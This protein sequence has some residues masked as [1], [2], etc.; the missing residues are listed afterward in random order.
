MEFNLRNY[1]WRRYQS[2]IEHFCVNID[3]DDDEEYDDDEVNSKYDDEDDENE[4][5]IETLCNMMKSVLKKPNKQVV[6][7]C[8]KRCTVDDLTTEMVNR[9]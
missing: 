1:Q 8:S 6:I 4:V 5:K 3:D 7:F 2:L 9:G